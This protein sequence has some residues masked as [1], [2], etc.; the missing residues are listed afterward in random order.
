MNK[1]KIKNKWYFID[2]EKIPVTYKY[3]KYKNPLL[4]MIYDEVICSVGLDK[5][6]NPWCH[7]D[8]YYKNN[9]LTFSAD[10]A[11]NGKGPFLIFKVYK[12]HIKLTKGHLLFDSEKKRIFYFSDCRTLQS[13]TNQFV[14]FITKYFSSFQVVRLVKNE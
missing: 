8:L 12:T 5:A 10:A 1:S 11:G 3:K 7:F 9:E 6:A 2:E 4:E 14:N 13:F